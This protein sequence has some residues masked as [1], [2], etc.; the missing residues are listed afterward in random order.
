MPEIKDNY[1][2]EVFANFRDGL[3]LTEN[4]KEEEPFVRELEWLSPLHEEGYRRY[5]SF[6]I[7]GIRRG[8]QFAPEGD[9]P[10]WDG[11]AK[12]VITRKYLFLRAT[13]DPMSLKGDNPEISDAEKECMLKVFK[14]LNLD[15][16]IETWY[17][18]YYPVA[19]ELTYV[20]L[21]SDPLAGNL[22]RGYRC[23]LVLVSFVN[24]RR[25]VMTTKEEWQSFY[26]EMIGKMFGPR[27][28]PYV[29][30]TVYFEV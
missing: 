27:G 6:E 18:D 9:G 10:L 11:V 25:G 2:L 24:N 29:V 17:H 1:W 30:F 14:M 4:V 8:E 15:G 19:R 23:E 7:E 16:D 3:V 26:E 13:D 28:I 21:L 22:G 5:H 20:T 12:D